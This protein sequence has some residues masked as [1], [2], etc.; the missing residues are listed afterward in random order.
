MRLL[1]QARKNFNLRGQ[2][3]KKDLKIIAVTGG[4]GSGKT[5]YLKQLQWTLESLGSGKA[6]EPLDRAVAEGKS[7]GSTIFASLHWLPLLQ[8]G[9]MK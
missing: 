1:L 8:N 6:D 7:M 4:S 5:E 9:I 3:G 2:G